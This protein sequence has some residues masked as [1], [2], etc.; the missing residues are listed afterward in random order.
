VGGTRCVG[1]PPWR[2]GNAAVTT[3]QRHRLGS[4]SRQVAWAPRDR[5]G[6]PARRS[7]AGW[8]GA[9][10]GVATV[11]HVTYERG[12]RTMRPPSE[13]RCCATARCWRQGR[14]AA[15]AQVCGEPEPVTVTAGHTR[16]TFRVAAIGGSSLTR[17]A[18][19]QRA[20]PPSPTGG[21][22]TVGVWL[23]QPT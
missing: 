1:A 23:G 8:M 12:G 4:T 22:T 20:R 7:A 14:P 15:A 18:P 5:Q 21:R 10:A 2:V 6:G 11:W 9:G 13:S 3:V 16:Y 19:V 17:T